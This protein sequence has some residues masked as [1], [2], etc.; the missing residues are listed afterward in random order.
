MI[1]KHNGSRTASVAL[2]IPIGNIRGN[3]YGFYWNYGG[4]S[5]DEWGREGKRNACGIWAIVAG[6]EKIDYISEKEF[7]KML[8]RRNISKGKFFN[9]LFTKN[10]NI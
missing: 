3:R 9:Y 8:E 1:E 4:I 6:K 7:W 2:F 5:F 10:F